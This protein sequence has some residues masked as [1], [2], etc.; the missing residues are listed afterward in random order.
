MQAACGAHLDTLCRHE[1]FKG[2]HRR[3][4]GRPL[5]KITAPVAA[6]VHDDFADKGARQQEGVI[7][8]SACGAASPAC[9]LDLRVLSNAPAK[10][11]TKNLRHQAGHIDH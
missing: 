2:N 4:L 10:G 8:L 9:A 7:R 6:R 1:P 11:G 3:D 5:T